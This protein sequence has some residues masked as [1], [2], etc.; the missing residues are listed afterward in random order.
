[1][2]HF[3][4]RP[5]KNLAESFYEP[6]ANSEEGIV[7][8]PGRLA[9]LSVGK[10][11]GTPAGILPPALGKFALLVHGGTRSVR[12]GFDVQIRDHSLMHFLAEP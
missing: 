2:G 10:I 3:C 5:D 11:P 8:V 9:I 4:G 1:M 6:C 7:A 12:P